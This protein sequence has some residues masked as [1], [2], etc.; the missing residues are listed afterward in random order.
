MYMTC[1]PTRLVEKRAAPESHPTTALL[2]RSLMLVP[3]SFDDRELKRTSGDARW[4]SG[5]ALL[6]VIGSINGDGPFVIWWP[7]IPVMLSV[8]IE[9]KEAGGERKGPDQGAQES[10][11]GLFVPSSKYLLS[12]GVCARVSLLLEKGKGKALVG[13]GIDTHELMTR[14]HNLSSLAVMNLAKRFLRQ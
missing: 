9:K 4:L 6:A 13:L 3:S 8:R 5:L 7:K 11:D 2:Q 14:R 1:L 10:L 12:L